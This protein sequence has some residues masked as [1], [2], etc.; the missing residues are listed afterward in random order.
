MAVRDG[1][2]RVEG[3][4]EVGQGQLAVTCGDGAH[5]LQE[6]RLSHLRVKVTHQRHL[7]A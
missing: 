1:H 5:V 6:G 7:H 2:L 3:D 4:G